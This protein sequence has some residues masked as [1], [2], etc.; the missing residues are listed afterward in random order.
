MMAIIGGGVA[1]VGASQTTFLKGPA[2]DKGPAG[3][4]GPKGDSGPKVGEMLSLLSM[5]IQIL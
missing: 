1:L 3:E 4:V 5:F 2:G